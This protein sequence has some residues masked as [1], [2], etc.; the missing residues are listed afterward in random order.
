M[1]LGVGAMCGLGRKMRL[2][3]GGLTMSCK[4]QGR[5]P[6][7]G[8]QIEKEFG[9]RRQEVQKGFQEGF[10]C[11][12]GY[13]RPVPVRVCSW[14]RRLQVTLARKRISIGFQCLHN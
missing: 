5:H 13:N 14:K 7:M 10:L 3:P 1:A 9:K 11:G 2:T 6:A 12:V 8:Q 4:A